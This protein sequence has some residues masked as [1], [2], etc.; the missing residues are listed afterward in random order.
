MLC[1]TVYYIQINTFIVSAS[2][3]FLISL[4]S[5]SRSLSKAI[6][7]ARSPSPR[8]SVILEIW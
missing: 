4:S 5:I 6:L 7:W 1:S 8:Y 2:F 3:F